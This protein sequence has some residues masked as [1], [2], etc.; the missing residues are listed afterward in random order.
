MGNQET[1]SDAVISTVHDVMLGE[2]DRGCVL[3]GASLIEWQMAELLR[4][5][6]LE[7]HPETTAKLE[8]HINTMLNPTSEKSI[9]GAAAAR[10]RMCRSLNLISEQMYQLL[11]HFLV[12]RNDHFAHAHSNVRFTDPDIKKGLDKLMRLVPEGFRIL[13]E[14]RVHNERDTYSMLVVI[15]YYSLD[16]MLQGDD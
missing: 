10:A 8:T 4:A 11:K 12:F 5:V 15:L 2:S 13:F 7:M 16:Y 9:L 6:F 1:P 3:V 14:S